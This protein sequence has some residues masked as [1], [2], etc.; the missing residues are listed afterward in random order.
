MK[1]IVCN[2]IC[3]IASNIKYAT[4]KLI[5]ENHMFES[6]FWWFVVLNRIQIES[7][8]NAN[9]SQL[10]SSIDIKLNFK[11]NLSASLN[12]TIEISF[13]IQIFKL[14]LKFYSNFAKSI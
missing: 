11:E 8:Y 3:K 2:L 7:N 5:S 13:R 1:S 6:T 10:E 4:Y 14:F 12:K 9:G